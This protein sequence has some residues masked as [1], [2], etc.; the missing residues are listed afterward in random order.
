M[1]TLSKLIVTGIITYI[2]PC[3][4]TKKLLFDAIQKNGCFAIKICQWI[5]VR[6]KFEVVQ[7]MNMENIF[8]QN[9]L[10]D[11][12]FTKNVYK[13]GFSRDIEEDFENIEIINSGSISQVYKAYSKNLNKEVVIKIKHPNVTTN[14]VS[15]W[16]FF[17]LLIYISKITGLFKFLKILH[18][19]ESEKLLKTFTD[20]MDLTIEADNMKYFLNYYENSKFVIIPELY[21]YNENIIIMSYE[22]STNIHDIEDSYEKYKNVM[23]LLCTTRDITYFSDKLH[24]DLH[25]GNW[26]IQNG[27]IVFYDFGY[28]IPH[29]DANKE[30]VKQW[31]YLY[32]NQKTNQV[33]D[34]IF[35]NHVK[36]M[37]IDAK[38]PDDWNTV[39][40]N[41][42]ICLSVIID[43][44]ELYKSH[45]VNISYQGIELMLYFNCL[46]KII[47]ENLNV[48][49]A[50]CDNTEYKM[51]NNRKDILT[52]SKYYNFNKL[53][54][55]INTKY[56][57]QNYDSFS[58]IDTSIV[59]QFYTSST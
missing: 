30:Y 19:T 15:L 10:H 29:S 58:K 42:E 39:P 52:F 16:N 51:H 4:K 59:A 18:Y 28:V 37:P 48:N 44:C 41:I 46:E 31:L 25:T 47:S 14:V 17:K 43:V 40:M 45:N 26:G 27:K 20:Q 34:L 7:S 35:E 13:N 53:H 12:E 49:Y 24:C 56:E 50:K 36:N 55:F 3:R 6:N 57:H 33:M 38:V 21:D 32:E 11:F 5:C 8:A 1:W 2:Y 22:K 23:L 9:A 54:D